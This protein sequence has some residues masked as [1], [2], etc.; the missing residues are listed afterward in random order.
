MANFSGFDIL[1]HLDKLTPDG[2]SAGK[3][4]R[5]YHCPICNAHNFKVTI[6]G[7]K[8]GYYL[9][10][11]CLCMGTDAGKQKIIDTISPPWKKPVREKLDAAYTYDGIE[12]RSLFAVCQV[13]RTDD[14]QGS[15]KI[16]QVH[17]DGRKRKWLNGLPDDIRRKIHLYRIFEP[18]NQD[19]IKNGAPLLI[20]EGEKK[21]DDLHHLGIAATCAIGG[22]GKWRE[23]GYP[24]YLEDLEGAA[25]VI[26][27]DRDEPGMKHAAMIAE[28][29]PNARWLY[30]HPTSYMWDRIPKNKGYDVSDWIEDGATKEQILESI[31]PRRPE[32]KPETETVTTLPAPDEKAIGSLGAKSNRGMT[33][34][35]M[36]AAMIKDEVGHLLSF[37]A[38]TQNFYLDGKRLTLGRERLILSTQYGLPIKAGKEDVMDICVQLAQENTFNSIADY[39]DGCHN[40]QGIE[41]LTLANKIFGTDDPLQAVFVKK[42]LIAAVARAYRPGC[43]ADEVL[44]L[45]GPQGQKKSSFF[46][47]LSPVEEWVNGDGLRGGKTGDEEIRKAQK[48]WLIEVPEIDKTFKKACSSEL[49]AFMTQQGDWLRQLYEKMPEYYPRNSIM[50]GTTNEPEFFTDNTGNRRYTV[51][52]VLVDIIDSS[53]LKTHRDSIWAAARDAYR[54]GEIWYLTQAEKSL[55]AEQNLKWKIEHPWHDAIASYVR[56]IEEVSVNEILDRV[57]QLNISE[58]KTSQ[59]MQVAGI[60]KTLGFTKQPQKRGKP[61][62]WKRIAGEM[63]KGI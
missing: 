17:W 49:K 32:P 55:H 52:Q 3:N 35:Q 4:E 63:E 28:D 6:E 23:Y 11:G 15:R 46:T 54:A 19:A 62:L 25:V 30:A 8:A 41:L 13:R 58:R 39:L 12:D 24:N 45:Q 29:F 21:V 61:V 31:E 37:D 44:I 59:Q 27:P 38:A 42:W 51:V 47:E 2:G 60:L 5:S 53:W 43:K 40:T 9:T 14:G 34:L 10:R 22:A 50:A 7:P 48:T 57:L 18:I 56:V 20:V 26:C 16:W 33:T 1:Q 36:D